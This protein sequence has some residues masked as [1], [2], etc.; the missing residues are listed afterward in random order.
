MGFYIPPLPFKLNKDLRI[1][2]THYLDNILRAKARWIFVV[3]SEFLILFFGIS[4]YLSAV[5]TIFTIITGIL[6]FKKV[7]PSDF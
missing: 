1:S 5:A 6:F 3:K 4:A 2:T 7:A